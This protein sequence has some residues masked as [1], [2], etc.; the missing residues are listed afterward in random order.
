MNIDIQSDAQ[1]TVGVG[2]GDASGSLFTLQKPGVPLASKPAMP[3][4]PPMPRPPAARAPEIKVSDAQ[5]MLRDFANPSKQ[6]DSFAPRAGSDDSDSMTTGGDDD[7]LTQGSGDDKSVSDYVVDDQPEFDEERPSPGFAS[8]DDEK[9]HILWKLSRAKRNGMPVHRNLTIDSSIRELRNELKRVEYELSLSQSLR[10]QKK[11]LCLAVSG[12]EVLT[13]RY[14]LFDLQ[15][16]G[17]SSSVQDDIDSFEGVL[18]RLHDKYKDRAAMPPELQLLLML[19]SSA[20]SFHVTKSMMKSL[21]QPGGGGLGGLL[22]SMMGGGAS[23]PQPTASV[24]E[25]PS[26]AQPTPAPQRAPMRGPTA[27][28]GLFGQAPMAPEPMAPPGMSERGTKRPRDAEDSPRVSDVVSDTSG[29]SG[30]E[31]S[32]SSS[33]DDEDTALKIQTVPVGGGR[34]RGRGRGRGAAAGRGSKTVVTL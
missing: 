13:E 16:Q 22:Q 2:A 11:M 30:S 4:R 14:S 6:P 1:K 8:I 23:K 21:S 12:M 34:G 28:P 7:S 26:T 10:F 5:D 9:S 24:Q 15:L 33:S 27:M 18:T 25:M 19:V 3:P 32:G 29:S 17:W 20:V 31:A